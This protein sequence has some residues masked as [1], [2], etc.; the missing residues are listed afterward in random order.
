MEAEARVR[1]KHGEISEAE[2]AKRGDMQKLAWLD[3]Q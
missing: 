3:Q 1:G 2:E